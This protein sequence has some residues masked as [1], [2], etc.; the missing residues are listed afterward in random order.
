MTDKK[1]A[2]A[3]TNSQGANAINRPTIVSSN[4]R[5]RQR[6]RGNPPLKPI[7]V[8]PELEADLVATA[9]GGRHDGR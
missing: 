7:H 5:P 6:W 9:K 3:A 4:E 1:E 8:S 2:P